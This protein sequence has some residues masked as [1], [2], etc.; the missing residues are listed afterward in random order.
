MGWSYYCDPKF[1]KNQLV[2]KMRRPGYLSPGYTMLESRVVGNNFWFL[3]E[4]PDK[5]K[6]I[7]LTLMQSGGRDGYGWGEKGIDETWGPCELNCPLTLLAKADAPLNEHAR[8]WREKV[9]EYHKTKK[10]RR[11]LVKPGAVVNYGGELY[12]LE[13]SLG[14]KGWEVERESDG[15]PM[16]MKAHQV[17]RS[18]VVPTETTSAALAQT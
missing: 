12:R 4:T 6:A 15:M 18:K 1:G 14:R 8:A 5:V 10:E 13:R 3:F 7:G 9:V 17:A 11:T 2:E 16:R